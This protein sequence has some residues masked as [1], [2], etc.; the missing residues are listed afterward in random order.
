M[1]VQVSVLVIWFCFVLFFYGSTVY[2]DIIYTVLIVAGGR[3]LFE[4]R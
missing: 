4:L 2:T 1:A 3:N